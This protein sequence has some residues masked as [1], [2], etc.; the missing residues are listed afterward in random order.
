MSTHLL[1]NLRAGRLKGGA[2][3]RVLTALRAAAAH[4]ACVVHETRSVAEL[5]S[6]AAEIALARPRAIVLAGGDGTIGAGVTSLARAW[7]AD[8][9][10]RGEPPP[11][12]PRVGIVPTGTMSTV[13]RNLGLVASESLAARVVARACDGASPTR[14]LETLRVTD[15]RGEARLG[16]M[17]GAG[18]VARFFEVYEA[19]GARGS[20]GAARII[21]RVFASSLVAGAAARRMLTP[22]PARL[23]VDG[24]ARP[25]DAYSLVVAATVKNL[26]LGLRLTYRAGD[27]PSRVH[28]VAS[29]LG[30]RG[31]GPQLPLVLLGRRLLGRANTDAL[32]RTATLDF[33]GRPAPYIL[34]GDLFHAARVTLTPGPTLEV[35]V[36]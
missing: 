29:A 25:A 32:A 13:A 2:P 22:S 33:G 1:V 20:A 21:A 15:E 23:T 34:D 18:L 6:A 4:G 19:D 24:D 36:A 16:F 27:D 30:P 11:T 28:V 14:T 26:G 8:A 5:E 9:A 7:A 31:L 17:F 12:L 3:S 10:A 35:V